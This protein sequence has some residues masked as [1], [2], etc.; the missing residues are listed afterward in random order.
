M[1]CLPYIWWKSLQQEIVE[2][3]ESWK[4]EIGNDVDI[5]EIR[6]L[7]VSVLTKTVP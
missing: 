1:Y 3:V 4:S 6:R 2:I 7:N 5:V